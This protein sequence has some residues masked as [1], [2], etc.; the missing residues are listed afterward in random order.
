MAVLRRDTI[1]IGNELDARVQ[2]RTDAQGQLFDPDSIVDVTILESDGSTVIETILGASVTKLSLGTYQAITATLTGLPRTVLDRWRFRRVAGGPV[3]QSTEDTRVAAAGVPGPGGFYVLIQDVRDA[4]ITVTQASDAVVLAAINLWEQYVERWTRNFFRQVNTVV[5]FDGNNS[6][7]L[8]MPIPMIAVNS[9]KVNSGA[10]ALPATQFV[11]HIGRQAP[12]DDRWNPRIELRALTS[13]THTASG[14]FRKGL[15]QVVDG[16]WGFLESDGSTPQAIIRAVL[17]LVVEDIRSGGAGGG[18]ASGI[19]KREKTD[20]HEVEYSEAGG[21]AAR[22]TLPRDVVDL[23]APYRAPFAIAAPEP[24]RPLIS[25]D[26]GILAF[27]V[28]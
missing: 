13:L 28:T 19:I 4:G 3:F 6:R 27:F 25:T 17:K 26:E 1:T 18:T 21:S 15:D 2:F 23:L 14:V 12:K 10:A 8:F 11:A 7:M 20:D 9:L 5:T 16:A 22:F 24:I